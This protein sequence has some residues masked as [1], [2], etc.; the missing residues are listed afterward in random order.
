M[1][2][3]LGKPTSRRGSIAADERIAKIDRCTAG[4]T[5]RFPL[6]DTAKVFQ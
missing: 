2:A 3:R 5:G 6:A 4:W 1:K